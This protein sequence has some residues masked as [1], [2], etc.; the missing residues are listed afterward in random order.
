MT[1]DTSTLL[2]PNEV[3]TELGKAHKTIMRWIHSGQLPA[4][5]MNKYYYIQR[6]DLDAY[7][8]VFIK[9][10]I[11]S[12]SNESERNTTPPKNHNNPNEKGA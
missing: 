3:A 6:S 12:D 5:K 2:T 10:Y 8:E 11:P 4:I 9:Q 7:K 1:L